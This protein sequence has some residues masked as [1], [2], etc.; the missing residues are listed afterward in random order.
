M[1]TNENTE[2]K[3]TESKETD[4]NYLDEIDEAFNNV[5]TT[6]ENNNALKSTD[7]KS[8]SIPDSTHKE[9]IDEDEFIKSNFTTNPFPSSNTSNPID[10]TKNKTKKPTIT[11]IPSNTKKNTSNGNSD[12]SSTAKTDDQLLAEIKLKEKQKEKEKIKK[13][14]SNPNLPRA[15]KVIIVKLNK[16]AIKVRPYI[17][18]VFSFVCLGHD[19]E[20]NKT[21]YRC[22]RNITFY[23]ALEFQKFIK[24]FGCYC[25]DKQNNSITLD[26]LLTDEQ[27]D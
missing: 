17:D 1:S 14:S 15:E 10:S 11:K 8:N 20:I 12:I 3:D 27:N 24:R 16:G 22:Y 18:K 2:N 9:E 26:Q 25:E 4:I 5:T 23:Q 6:K 7:N 21:C 19:E 13:T